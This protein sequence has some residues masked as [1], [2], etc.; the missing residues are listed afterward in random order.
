MFFI[1][2]DQLE[3][4]AWPAMNVIAIKWLQVILRLVLEDKQLENSLLLPKHMKMRYKLAIIISFQNLKT[5][6]ICLL[7]IPLILFGIISTYLLLS[8]NTHPGTVDPSTVDGKTYRPGL[9]EQFREHKET[10][11]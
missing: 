9:N 4:N 6:L 2:N 3:L 7:L 10:R 8:L 11:I 1:T 5:A